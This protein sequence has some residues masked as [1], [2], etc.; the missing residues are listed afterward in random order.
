MKKE[1]FQHYY[2]EHKHNKRFNATFWKFAVLA[3][4]VGITLAFTISNTMTSNSIFSGILSSSGGGS[5]VTST[6]GTNQTHTVCINYQCV[7]INGSGNNQCLT[8]NDCINQTTQVT[9]QGVLNMLENCIVTSSNLYPN[10]TKPFS[11]SDVCKAY[12][13]RFFQNTTCVSTFIVGSYIENPIG[14]LVK[15]NLTTEHLKT[16]CCDAKA[17]EKSNIDKRRGPTAGH[18]CSAACEEGG[19]PEE[20]CYD[21]CSAHLTWDDCDGDYIP[22]KC[23]LE[24]EGCTCYWGYDPATGDPFPEP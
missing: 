7:R 11:G 14:C 20:E 5:S 16:V 15:I 12:D 23:G 13:A 21:I 1:D 3:V 8:N 18:P 6:N 19:S 4:A 10:M 17:I 24:W 22:N 2:S 9:Y